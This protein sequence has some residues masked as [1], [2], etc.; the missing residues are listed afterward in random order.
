M[1]KKANKKSGEKLPKAYEW[2]ERDIEDWNAVTYRAYLSDRHEELYGI[3]YVSYNYAM[4]GG[5]IKRTYEKYGKVATKSFI[6]ACF[7]DY[8]PSKKYPGINFAFMYT[9]MRRLLP[10]VL[11]K[12]RDEK[13]KRRRTITMETDYERIAELL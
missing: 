9:Y 8:K 4:E 12:E 13:K 5:M 3:P 1:S 11:A 10:Q 6:D 7:A 2:E